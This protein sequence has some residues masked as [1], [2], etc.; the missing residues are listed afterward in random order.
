M[1]EV[2]EETRSHSVMLLR[3]ASRTSERDVLRSSMRIEPLDFANSTFVEPV[4][5]ENYFF[6]YVH[7]IL[8]LGHATF[9]Q[10]CAGRGTIPFY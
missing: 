1:E 6:S 3:S 4:G 2:R 5:F 8:Y 9:G 10:F 7:E